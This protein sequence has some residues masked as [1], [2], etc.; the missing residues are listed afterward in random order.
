MSPLEA[1]VA[2]NMLPRI[3]PVR[4]RRLLEAFG[5]PSAILKAPEELLKR[6]D[7]I[8]QET[9]GI[10]RAW[11]DHADPVAEI[12][13]AKERGISIVTQ[14]DADYP[15][16][17]REAYDPPLLLYVWGKIEPRDR[18]AIGVV[19]WRRATHY[20]TQATRKLSY[21]LA[22]SGFTILSGLARGIDTAYHAREVNIEAGY[23]VRTETMGD[24]DGST[25]LG[26]N[27]LITKSAGL[28]L[29]MTGADDS[30][31][32]L[33][34]NLEFGLIG[35]IPLNSFAW[36]FGTGAEFAL[37]TD[38]WSVYAETGPRFRLGRGFDLFAKVRGTRPIAG[39]EG[40][41]VAILAGLSYAFRP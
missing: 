14:N 11:Q 28:H 23:M 16:P 33:I 13:E 32:D 36:E 4:V 41:N 3:G 10:I 12:R 20:G 37:H 27:Y 1:L 7:G 18:H 25:Y 6:V 17:L 9:A 34:R 15:A 22:Q 29:G 5:D 19:G 38:A 21:Q 40:E 35:R 8:G 26:A 31:G 39:A 30:Q 2:L 24:F